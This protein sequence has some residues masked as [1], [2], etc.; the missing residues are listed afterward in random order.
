MILRLWL[1]RWFGS[2]AYKSFL[3]SMLAYWGII[4]LIVEIIN[5]LFPGVVPILLSYRWYILILGFFYVFYKSWPRSSFVYQ[6]SDRDTS[7]ELK[8]ADAFTVNGALVVPT[9]NL[10]DTELLGDPAKAPSIEGQLIQQFFDGNSDYL[11]ME[12]D[13]QLSKDEYKDEI[14]SNDDGQ[15]IVYKT[16]TTIR[17][18]KNEKIFYLIALTK[19]NEHRRAYGSEEYLK[20]SLARLWY[21][22]SER[23]DKGVLIAPI[24][25]TGHARIKIKREEVIKSIVRSFIA[26][27][28]SKT[29]CDNLV[30]VL[31][32]RDVISHQID[33]EAIASFIEYSCKYAQFDLDIKE[34]IGTGLS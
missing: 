6:I 14:Q 2:K 15:D 27:C 20:L 28:S 4:S 26:S 19:L 5:G 16:G 32:P 24:F 13:R 30:I 22:I 18:Q 25:G 8:I 31:N 23:G 29:Y 33:V 7:I 1:F 11:K 34:N 3:I 21:W 12:I 10:F 9:N 17:I